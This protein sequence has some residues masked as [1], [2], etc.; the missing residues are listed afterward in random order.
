MYQVAGISS[1][2]AGCGGFPGV[3]TRVTYFL[4]WIEGI[5]WPRIEKIGKTKG[6]RYPDIV[7]KI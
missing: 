3:Y 1:F 5:V 6:K 4:E 7:D 2:G